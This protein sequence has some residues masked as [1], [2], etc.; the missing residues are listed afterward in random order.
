MEIGRSGL[1]S[2]EIASSLIGEAESW[3]RKKRITRYFSYVDQDDDAYKATLE[4]NG[5][6]HLPAK[7]DQDDHY[8]EKQL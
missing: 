4:A 7:D 5:F 6:L 2:D 3:L 1:R 8:L